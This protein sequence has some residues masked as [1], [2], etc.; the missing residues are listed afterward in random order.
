MA[1]IETPCFKKSDPLSKIETYRKDFET[2]LETVY[3][4]IYSD[5][6]WASLI[7]DYDLDLFQYYF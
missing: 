2:A 6:E 1:K 5:A 7:A 3:D 4:I